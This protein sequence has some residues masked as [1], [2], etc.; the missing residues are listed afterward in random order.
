MAKIEENKNLKKFNTLNVT[1][2]ADKFIKIEEIEDLKSLSE[3]IAKENIHILGGGSNVIMRS[4][5]DGVVL[6]NKIRERKVLNETENEIKIKI[7]SGENWDKFVRYCVSQK[8]YGIENLALI[9]GTVGGAIIQN[10]GAYGVEIKDVLTQVTAINLDNFELEK[11][12]NQDCKFDYR[13]SIFKTNQYKNYFITSAEFKL[14]KRKEFNLSY[15]SLK[16]ELSEK[17]TIQTVYD[18]VS[19]IR[20]KK[21]PNW[22]EVG[23]AGSFF[24]N[25]FVTKEKL[26]ELQDTYPDIP[27]FPT[28]NKIKLS[29]GWLIDQIQEKLPKKEDIK[30]Y[31]KHALI[32]INLGNAQGEDIVQYTDEIKKGVYNEFGLK[33]EREVRLW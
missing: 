22:E 17:P 13:E 16:K 26:Q 12:N 10:A 29:A 19:K 32:I 5:I 25:P 33:L 3:D 18:T 27:H 2:Q 28:E 6:H 30:P 24:K 8:Y 23:T 21:L 14:K 1:C 15:G 11:F 7:G 9:P 4:N 31:K 20:N